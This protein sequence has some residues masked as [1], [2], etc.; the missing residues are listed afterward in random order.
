MLKKLS[1]RMKL[2]FLM[3][4]SLTIVMTFAAFITINFFKKELAEIFQDE[5]VEKVEFLNL[6][7]ESYL[8]TPIT[9]VGNT[10]MDVS[11][12]STPEEIASLRNDLKMKTSGVEGVLGLHVAFEGDKM[13]HSSR[14]VSL[15]SN[16]DS[17]TRDWYIESIGSPNDVIVTDPYVDAITGKLII[18][19]SKALEDGKGVVTL[20][21]DLAFLEDLVSNI[22]IGEEGYTFVFDN[23]GNVLYH[24]TYAQSE[25]VTNLP[26]YQDFLENDYIKTIHNKDEVHINRFYNEMMNWQIGSIYSNKEIDKKY[27]PMVLPVTALNT[28]SILLL[29]AIFFYIITKFLRPLNFVTQFA[30]K[31]AQGNLKDTVKINSQDEVG[32]LSTSFNH[33][34]TGLKRMIHQV[35][36]TAGKLNDFSSD[37]SASIEENVQSISQV[38]E[39]IQTVTNETRDQVQFAHNVQQSVQQM[40]KEISNIAD[41]IHDVQSASDTAEEQ[42][43]TGVNVMQNVMHQMNL[44]NGN[45]KETA[46]NFNTLISVANEIDNFSKVISGIADQTNLLALNASIEAA[47]AGEHGKG[48]AV[49]AEEVR[50]LAE[51]TS[52]SVNEIQTLV[53]TIHKTGSIANES[54]E[55]NSKAVYEGMNQIQSASEMF[56]MI[57]QVMS[58]LS[59]K[60]DM[61]Q[62]AIQ[63]LQVRKEEAIASVEEIVSASQKVSDNVEQVAATTEEQNAS[64]EQ[65]AVSAQHLSQ[66]AQELQQSIQRFEI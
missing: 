65:M 16:Y 47:R 63:S 21:L 28:I 2:I 66:Q 5:T 26:F 55:A 33:M 6:Y 9:L 46:N 50:K 4:V 37:V 11:Y 7:L 59:E 57:H 14:D 18:S 22:T 1:I 42:T 36:E 27:K 19:V 24:P 29:C 53:N 34:T 8:A 25:S 62:T 15:D 13:L 41:N 44:I 56:N 39:N 60:V 12:V 48:F 58:Q 17:N 49:V 20:D 32:K 40:D 52:T 10:A 64:M 23:S 38:V 51:Q 45:A 35:D 43:T 31:V 54:I 30:E 3:A 61:T